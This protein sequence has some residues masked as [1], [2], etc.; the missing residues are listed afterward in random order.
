MHVGP[1]HCHH[2]DVC[3]Q[4]N[5]NNNYKSIQ[6]ECFILSLISHHDNV[7][8]FL[9]AVVDEGELSTQ[10]PLMYKMMMEL[11]DSES[12]CNQYTDHWTVIPSAVVRQCYMYTYLTKGGGGRTLFN[13]CANTCSLKF[14][15][16]KV[17]FH[18]W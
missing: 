9:G 5:K 7:V 13:V 2:K 15:K 18:R 8:R 4:Q 6:H 1:G 16:N 12:V 14:C 3:H 17:I 10:P 11:A